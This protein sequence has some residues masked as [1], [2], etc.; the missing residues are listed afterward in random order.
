MAN[1]GPKTTRPQLLS[2]AL[3]LAAVATLAGLAASCS[4]TE[5]PPPQAAPAPRPQPAAPQVDIVSLTT[6]VGIKPGGLVYPDVGPAAAVK[7]SRGL[8]TVR[9]TGEERF[10]DATPNMALQA[11]DVLRTGPHAEAMIALA[12][13]TVIQLAEDTAI[14]IGN[15]AILPDP[16]SSAAVLYGVARMSI[17]PRARGEGAFLAVAGDNYVGAKGTVFVAAVSVGGL[18]RIGVEHG[19][20]DVAGAAALDKPVSVQK[21]EAVEVDPKGV[22]GQPQPFKQDDWGDWRY[23]GEGRETVAA[24][25]RFHADR[26]VRNEGRL[27]ADYAIFQTLATTASTLT[28]RAEANAKPKGAADYKATALDRAATIDATFRMAAEIA[29]LTNCA[30]SDALI[31]GELY[32]R[33][34]KEVEPQVLEFAQE[35]AGALLY[36][37]KLQVISEIFLVPLRAAYYAHTAR[38]RIQAANLGMPTPPSAPGKLAPSSA[39]EIAKR[40]PRPLY[41]APQL[42]STTRP[43]PVWQAAPKLGWEQRLTLTP[44]PPRQGAW[45]IAPTRVE[46]RLL[47]GV[48]AS[49]APRSSFPS[50]ETIEPAKAEVAFLVPPLPPMTTPDAGAP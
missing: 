45:Y 6:R 20:V 48:R 47:V 25:A 43:H 46:A 33:H 28:W 19:E 39:A 42:E 30:L 14:A 12:D 7:T 35:M 4:K 49:Y 2:L 5:P 41:V 40:L 18:V 37:K 8:L 1:Q 22:V 3:S 50:A 15:R 9:R 38:G 29:R 10:V 16:A 24:A 17:S 23:A 44:V 34:P 11:G 27:D 21:A 13:N 26:L 32:A 31:L 36:N